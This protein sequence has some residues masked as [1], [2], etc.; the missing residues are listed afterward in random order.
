MAVLEGP[1]VTDESE[2]DDDN[3]NDIQDDEEEEGDNER[4]SLSHISLP[5]S[6][7]YSDLL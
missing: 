7:N 3:D 4:Y 1:K 2:G 5:R 6:R